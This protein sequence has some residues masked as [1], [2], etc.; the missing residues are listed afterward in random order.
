MDFPAGLAAPP[1]VPAPAVPDAGDA[2]GVRVK[3]LRQARGWTLE[4]ASRQTGMSLSALSKIERGALSPTVGSLRKIASGFGIDVVTL[5]APDSRGAAAGR[6]SVN[7]RPDG[8]AHPT[9]TCRNTWLAAD[10]TQKRMQP[11]L[12][13][14][15]ARSPEEYAEWARHPGEIFVH[16]LQGTMVLH[17]EAYAPL[18]LHAGDS[19]YYDA[20][21][22]SK[23][24][25]EGETDAEVLWL[26][27][28]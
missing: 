4:A 18:V 22:G 27:S 16:V 24:T 28:A 15:I 13:R 14:V 8:I 20:A 23:W 26:Y 11:F 19:V 1:A 7:R 3:A 12:S 25:S 21:M 5:L 17:S 9:G 2:L 10:L 6:R